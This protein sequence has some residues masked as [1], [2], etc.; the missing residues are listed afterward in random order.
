MA[1]HFL[2]GQEDVQ[3]NANP[4]ILTVNQTPA[5]ISIV[6]EISINNGAV[7]IDT[8]KGTSFEKS[9]TRA[10]YGTTLTIIPTIHQP[11]EGRG[12]G[13]VTLNTDI[14]FDTTQMSEDSR[15]PV[16][17]RHVKNEIQVEDGETIILG[18]LRRK[19]NT[20]SQEKIPFLGEI[21][22]VGKL[23]GFQKE[24]D[25]NS[26]MFIFITPHIVKDTVQDRESLRKKELEKRPGDIPEFLGKLEEAKA[27]KKKH[28]FADSLDFILGE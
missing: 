27:K 11:E 6:E 13:V 4:S 26:E 18:G 22:G 10:Q 19:S 24:S 25:V 9:F 12:K 17:R 14:T 20:M 8:S 5:F 1:Y 7:P 3:I 2:M 23:F 21:P 15:P 16:T 28:L